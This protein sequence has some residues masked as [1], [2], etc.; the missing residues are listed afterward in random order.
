L[1]SKTASAIAMPGQIAIQDARSMWVRPE[2]MPPQDD[3]GRDA[4][5]KAEAK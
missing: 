1:K 4:E 2:S 3:R 5:A